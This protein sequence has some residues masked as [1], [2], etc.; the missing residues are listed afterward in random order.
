MLLRVTFDVAFFSLPSPQTAD[1]A[2]RGIL[3]PQKSTGERPSSNHQG[4]PLNGMGPAKNF[5]LDNHQGS[6]PQLLLITRV[7]PFSSC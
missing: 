4:S 6:P 2:E 7:L 1:S 5:F 3:R